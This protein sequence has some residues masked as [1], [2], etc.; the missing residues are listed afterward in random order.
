MIR[1]NTVIFFIVWAVVG[2]VYF[3]F[4]T[5]QNEEQWTRS[6]GH[7]AETLVAGPVIWVLLALIT[8]TGRGLMLW[9]RWFS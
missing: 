6:E 3:V 5:V 8:V 4:D 9:N 7:W 1:M 2:A